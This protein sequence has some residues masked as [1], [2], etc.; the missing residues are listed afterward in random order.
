MTH[1]EEQALEVEVG[2][3]RNIISEL[4]ERV[5]SQARIIH[6]GRFHQWNDFNFCQNPECVSARK[7]VGK[8]W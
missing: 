3:L 8:E 5:L 4:S 6:H 7:L 2:K 1:A